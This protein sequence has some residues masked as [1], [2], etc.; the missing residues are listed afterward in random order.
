M[1][2]HPDAITDP[3]R[4]PPKV[5]LPAVH[6][7]ACA[8]LRPRHQPVRPQLFRMEQLGLPP[9]F[10]DTVAD[11]AAHLPWDLYDVARRRREVLRRH[12]SI[13]APAQ[14]A[15]LQDDDADP[16]MVWNTLQDALPSVLRAAL[17]RI[18]P[19]RRRAM[20]KYVAWRASEACW[21]LQ[22]LDDTG[23]EQ[24]GGAARA[25]RR[26]FAPIVP[27]L[28][29]HPDMLRLVAGIAETI[30]QRCDATR[31]QLVVHQMMT[32]AHGQAAAEPAPEGLHQD[33]AD[34]VVSALV[35]RR[36]GVRGG[37]SRV[38]HGNAGP[39][40]LEQTLGVG[41]GLFHP[42]AGSPLWHEVSAL[43]AAHPDQPGH[44]LILGID[45]H[46]LPEHSP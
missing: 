4:T 39:L 10:L 8:L 6:C 9:S 12:A 20:R 2:A 34:Y 5:A 33:G 26:V 21:R 3:A 7:L 31:L 41:D 42:D 46:V 37:V 13:L 27:A 44:R 17:L 29:Y 14:R 11:H 30:H 40:L 19:H 15:L 38:R 36:Q 1:H 23:F 25:P 24:P 45:A 28:T 18:Q 32:V 35:I 22:P 43:H 16:C